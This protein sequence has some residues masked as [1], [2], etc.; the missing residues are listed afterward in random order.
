MKKLLIFIFA[1]ML[2]ASIA[3]VSAAETTETPISLKTN[4]GPDCAMTVVGAAGI[5]MAAISQVMQAA[6][7]ILAPQAAATGFLVNAVTS[8]IPGLSDVLKG[9]ECVDNPSA[10]ATDQL[11]NVATNLI[12]SPAGPLIK[13]GLQSCT[14]AK[15]TLKSIGANKTVDIKVDIQNES[16]KSEYVGNAKVNDLSELVGQ[17]PGSGYLVVPNGTEVNITNDNGK[18]SLK[19]KGSVE[20]VKIGDK[21][22]GNLKNAEFRLDKENQIEFAEF[23]TT[24]VSNYNFSY[25]GTDYKII[26]D[27]GGHVLFDP[28]N[29][30]IEGKNNVYLEFSE[31]NYANG[32]FSVDLNSDGSINKVTLL[33]KNSFYKIGDYDIFAS[34]DASVGIYFNKDDVIKETNSVLFLKDDITLNGN[35]GVREWLDEKIKYNVVGSDRTTAE[36]TRKKDKDNLNMDLINVKAGSLYVTSQIVPGLPD[37][38]LLVFGEGN[39]ASLKDNGYLEWKSGEVV[40][41]SDKLKELIGRFPEMPAL[42][43]EAVTQIITMDDV[44]K[45]LKDKN[46][47]ALE[48]D[49]KN[50]KGTL[51][52]D[53]IK[54]LQYQ[55]NVLKADK[56]FE[57]GDYEKA[58]ADYRKLGM[59]EKAIDSKRKVYEATKEKWQKVKTA[60]LQLTDKINKEATDAV[61][62]MG[63]EFQQE[64]YNQKVT[65]LKTK[66]GFDRILKATANVADKLKAETDKYTSFVKS[67]T[68]TYS[69]S[70]PVQLIDTATLPP[71]QQK[72][73]TEEYDITVSLIDKLNANEYDTTFIGRDDKTKDL[74]KL[75]ETL[76]R[77]QNPETVKTI[78]EYLSI[79]A[80][81]A[82]GQALTDLRFLKEKTVNLPEESELKQAVSS[83]EKDDNYKNWVI[84][85]ELSNIKNSGVSTGTYLS[86]NKYLSDDEKNQIRKTAAVQGI[87]SAE[88]EL[89]IQM[90]NNIDFIKQNND[91]YAGTINVLSSDAPWWNKV[92]E[93][94]LSAAGDIGGIAIDAFNIARLAKT[95]DQTIKEESDKIIK[96][97]NAQ[98]NSINKLNNL[99]PNDKRLVL[100]E[101]AKHSKDPNYIMAFKTFKV[102]KD[103]NKELTPDDIKNI[104]AAEKK[105]DFSLTRSSIAETAKNENEVKA[106]DIKYRLANQIDTMKKNNLDMNFQNA[107]LGYDDTNFGTGVLSFA[108]IAVFSPVSL[109]KNVITNAPADYAKAED[110]NA[111]VLD[112]NQK[113]TDIIAE[114][115]SQ[116]K[117]ISDISANIGNLNLDAN[118]LANVKFALKNDADIMRIHA[119]EMEANGDVS[120]A[121]KLRANAEIKNSELNRQIGDL[122][123]A[124]ANLETASA[125]DPSKD[126]SKDI[127]SI[128]RQ[129]TTQHIIKTVVSMGDFAG[130]CYTLGVI[131]KGVMA[132]ATKFKVAAKVESVLGKI[133]FGKFVESGKMASALKTANTAMK[134]ISR[135]ETTSKF[136]GK[137]VSEDIILKA[138]ALNKELTL[139]T[140]SATATAKAEQIA[141][142][143]NKAKLETSIISPQNTAL[144]KLKEAVKEVITPV[145]GLYDPRGFFK[146]FRGLTE[147]SALGQVG[148]APAEGG[149]GGE[150]IS[151]ADLKVVS[152][153]AVSAVTHKMP[154]G[155]DTK[156]KEKFKEFVNKN[157][158][159]ISGSKAVYKGNR[160]ETVVRGNTDVVLRSG[161]KEIK[162]DNL[163]DVRF[164][165]SEGKVS[166]LN[167]RISETA[168]NTKYESLAKELEDNA[169]AAATDVDKKNIKNE[170][171]LLAPVKE[172]DAAKENTRLAEEKI[173]EAES[174]GEDTSQLKADY[175]NA[176]KEQNQKE[177]NYH[178]AK[179]EQLQKDILDLNSQISEKQ[180]QLEKETNAKKKESVSNDIQKLNFQLKDTETKTAQYKLLEKEALFKSAK[181]ELDINPDAK[182]KFDSASK[183]YLDSQDNLLAKTIDK[184]NLMKDILKN[185][186]AKGVNIFDKSVQLR[187]IKNQIEFSESLISD[188]ESQRSQLSN[189]RSIASLK[190]ELNSKESLSA[191]EAAV[192]KKIESLD[193]LNKKVAESYDKQTKLIDQILNADTADVEKVDALKTEILNEITS[194]KGIEDQ[195]AATYNE[196]LSA[197]KPLIETAKPSAEAVQPTAEIIQLA[198]EKAISGALPVEKQPVAVKITAESVPPEEIIKPEHLAMLKAAGHAS[199][200]ELSIISDVIDSTIDKYQDTVIEFLSKQSPEYAKLY[201]GALI[202]NLH[203]T[204]A[205]SDIRIDSLQGEI[206]RQIT[207]MR[208]DEINFKL[209]IKFPVT[210][211]TY[212][213]YVKIG[214]EKYGM[215]LAADSERG[216]MD[217][218]TGRRFLVI[219]APDFARL[220]GAEK[221]RAYKQTISHESA[222]VLTL[223]LGDLIIEKFNKRNDWQQIKQMFYDSYPE[224][225]DYKSDSEVINEILSFRAENKYLTDKEKQNYP[226]RQQFLDFIEKNV[227]DK[228]IKDT[229]NK[230]ITSTSIAT[231]RI[232]ETS[233][234]SNMMLEFAAEKPAAFKDPEIESAAKQRIEGVLPKLKQLMSIEFS[235]NGKE[236]LLEKTYKMY[237]SK[238]AGTIK[239]KNRDEEGEYLFDNVINPVSTA[240]KLVK[241]TGIEFSAEIEKDMISKVSD[242]IV[243]SGVTEAD[244]L[245]ALS[246]VNAVMRDAAKKQ[247]DEIAKDAIISRLNPKIIEKFKEY[248]E[249]N[250][251]DRIDNKIS[252]DE[253]KTKIESE[254]DIFSKMNDLNNHLSGLNSFVSDSI[255]KYPETSDLIKSVHDR[256][257]NGEKITDMINDVGRSSNNIYLS[258]LSAAQRSAI[259]IEQTLGPQFLKEKAPGE[260]PAEL[261]KPVTKEEID[262]YI[263]ILPNSLGDVPNKKA[264]ED[265]LSENTKSL[266]PSDG[267][268]YLAKVSSILDLANKDSYPVMH[269]IL[270]NL[271][272]ADAENFYEKAKELYTVK[273]NHPL[274][275]YEMERLLHLFNGGK[276]E[277]IKDIKITEE[278]NDVPP[279]YTVS[280]KSKDGA[281]IAD[282]NLE[283]YR[284]DKENIIQISSLKI[285]PSVYIGD[286]EIDMTMGVKYDKTS[287][288]GSDQLN[289]L[290]GIYKGV[291]RTA[292]KEGLE[293][294]TFDI[295][296]KNPEL[297]RLALSIKDY[298]VELQDFSGLK[299][300]KLKKS[301]EEQ[302]IPKSTIKKIIKDATDKNGNID[303]EKVIA[304]FDKLGV[305]DDRL[306]IDDVEIKNMIEGGKDINGN[307][308]Y[309]KIGAGFDKIGISSK[310][311]ENIFAK[312]RTIEDDMSI[313]R[314]E[315]RSIIQIKTDLIKE[316][317]LREEQARKIAEDEIKREEAKRLQEEADKQA[318]IISSEEMSKAQ[319]EA[320]K[321]EQPKI[322]S[323]KDILVDY[324]D[325]AID[326]LHARD[327]LKQ[328]KLAEN[329][330]DN[331]MVKVEEKKAEKR[332]GIIK[333][334]KGEVIIE[335]EKLAE[336]ESISKDYYQII[337]TRVHDNIVDA[338][339][340]FNAKLIDGSFTNTIKENIEAAQDGDL[341][342]IIYFKVNIEG[343]KKWGNENG[344]TTVTYDTN[345]K[346]ILLGPFPNKFLERISEQSVEA[347]LK[348]PEE[349]KTEEL[350]GP[351]IATTDKMYDAKEWN[352]NY[353]YKP[354]LDEYKRPLKD[355]KTG[356]IK[357]PYE[358]RRYED[359]GKYF[360]DE[361][362]YSQKNGRYSEALRQFEIAKTVS[363]S[364]SDIYKKA[365]EMIDNLRNQKAE[366]QLAAAVPQFLAEKA[367]VPEASAADVTKQIE[368]LKLKLKDP[369]V[370]VRMQAVTELGKIG[371]PAIPAVIELLKDPDVRDMATEILGNMREPAV[372]PLIEALKSPDANV[373]WKATIA[374]GNIFDRR[375]IEPLARLIK[376][377]D[378][379]VKQQAILVVGRFIHIGEIPAVIE[380]VPALIEEFKSSSNTV[381]THYAY[382]M[383]MEIGKPAVP[384]LIEALKDPNLYMSGR[385]ARALGGIR[386]ERAIQPLIELMKTNSMI[387]QTTSAALAEIGEPAVPALIELLKDHEK[388][389]MASHTLRRIGEPAVPALIELLKDPDAIVRLRA[390]VVLGDVEDSRAINPLIEL[391]KDPDG[392]VRLSAVNSLGEIKDVKAIPALISIAMQDLLLKGAAFDSLNIINPALREINYDETNLKI[393]NEYFTKEKEVI[394]PTRV[395]NY[396]E[397]LAENAKKLDSISDDG[398][399]WQAIKKITADVDVKYKKFTDAAFRNEKVDDYS[400]YV[401]TLGR[402]DEELKD[403]LDN[404]A[405]EMKISTEG[406]TIADLM[407]EIDS[408]LKTVDIKQQ[409]VVSFDFKKRNVELKLPADYETALKDNIKAAL[410]VR[411]LGDEQ[412]QSI[413][414]K[415]TEI[416]SKVDN[417]DTEYLAKNNVNPKLIE[418]AKTDP[419]RKENIKAQLYKHF[420]LSQDE[421]N[422]ILLK[423]FERSDINLI[424]KYSGE[425]LT[426]EEKNLFIQKFSE[427]EISLNDELETLGLGQINDNI[428]SSDQWSVIKDLKKNMLTISEKEIKSTSKIEIVF[429]KK[430]VIDLGY[431]GFSGTCFEPVDVLGEKVMVT[432]I[433]ENGELAGSVLFAIQKDKL[434]MLGFD[435][436]ESLVA[437]LDPAKKNEFIDNVMDRIYNFADKNNFKLMI[438]TQAGGLSNRGFQDY[439][440]KKY[441]TSNKINVD[442]MTYQPDYK[443]KVTY[444]FEA[445][446]KPAAVNEKLYVPSTDVI[447]KSLI[448]KELVKQ[449]KNTIAE[450]IQYIIENPSDEILDVLHLRAFRQIS[451]DIANIDVANLLKNQGLTAEDAAAK[452]NLVVGRVD[453]ISDE[454]VLTALKNMP[455]G[456][457]LFKHMEKMQL[458]TD[459][460]EPD[461]ENYLP[462]IITLRGAILVHD[463]GKLGPVDADKDTKKVIFDLFEVPALDPELKIKEAITQIK[464]DERYGYKFPESDNYYLDILNKVG[465]KS[466]DSISKLWNKHYEWGEDWMNTHL[467]EDSATY[468]IAKW[469]GKLAENDPVISIIDT[470]DALVSRP[471]YDPEKKR[472][473]PPKTHDE[474]IESIKSDLM[475]KGMKRSATFKGKSN[476]ELKQTPEYANYLK[477]LDLINQKKDEILNPPKRY[478]I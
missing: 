28:S 311:K 411:G 100:E 167:N 231:N 162:I 11:F 80:D 163:Q 14:N 312:L 379:Q 352:P 207:S 309:E 190:V 105:T 197:A 103:S 454:R 169:K 259:K 422:S 34:S 212:S 301:Y 47:D 147:F 146:G 446:E 68:T 193:K 176:L 132:G 451:S 318:K 119:D 124:K 385:A 305:R 447:D 251:N 381:V 148:G 110:Y 325:G 420:E 241:K 472:E 439:I 434:I 295:Y 30:K 252:A 427:M 77:T 344:I 416:S 275:T 210:P 195:L 235:E 90:K 46:I 87:G 109:I 185:E 151:L 337:A 349:F 145:T 341:G 44:N 4:L 236:V 117:S 114:L 150:K 91:Y 292:K 370:N 357:Y 128:G 36:I 22:F 95:K 280:V 283:I 350:K 303:N 83:I 369:D 155:Y 445:K 374:L 401:G 61:S 40:I 358:A 299:S 180:S 407:K 254:K 159:E 206:I 53:E 255:Y 220:K 175:S 367:A 267:L 477:I 173:K 158:G 216:L 93:V 410:D 156:L 338:K 276:T 183:E 39:T 443:Y 245:L 170:Q 168:I 368:D 433:L 202:L 214:G 332:S 403:N 6:N 448:T 388:G 78:T 278:K 134:E 111:N 102:F 315:E 56:E 15:E 395:Y 172:I 33:K 85:S 66:Y 179:T 200:E 120:S 387:W 65:E 192:S 293:K 465:L 307:F 290:E 355:F 62:G 222:H 126:L 256:I 230:I 271:D 432:K 417:F 453:Q 217:E 58:S 101:I 107:N 266:T 287:E 82:D 408:K 73:L 298:Y 306:E 440:M 108:K 270:K 153:I 123:A 354:P 139:A 308:D 20:A 333:Q 263:K 232:I 19:F 474:A 375:S 300:E 342:K 178:A 86:K 460:L 41:T 166:E 286:R 18:I 320:V 430:S 297:E 402:F 264:F 96:E 261:T 399:R 265:L 441:A 181:S 21:V 316:K 386:D 45:H 238:E 464:K 476:E 116:G 63:M 431:G 346:P 340:Y 75:R 406:K 182:S 253:L 187:E 221:I 455:Q 122:A 302:D 242:K 218:T 23:D 149:E 138:Q 205:K 240:E 404:V 12:P 130:A 335:L 99:E 429:K 467:P 239:F 246:D 393:I 250:I 142:L 194:R 269:E 435:P 98:L 35:A 5:N 258:H 466:G 154:K 76:Q 94:P 428:K 384:A 272:T 135:L 227:V 277:T 296:S 364:K 74:I 152:D 31:K 38:K 104:E 478:I 372:L 437:S 191:D 423:T 59:D 57:S 71:K 257:A 186:K 282:A 461:I 459:I 394:S 353:I 137:E 347:M 42:T 345:G 361:A 121:N 285:D 475:F 189:Q 70:P 321:N 211:I 1:M 106:A 327:K 49:L 237:E 24:A 67:Y 328:N 424:K 203:H 3:A 390:V 13:A 26:A 115:V 229:Y 470:Y 291:L 262:Y 456:T 288:M 436:S 336:K 25:G 438:T 392:D 383:I 17:K 208:P 118:S 376:D 125:L 363:S 442:P 356:K 84:Q 157:S 92:W 226:G 273:E 247:A 289:L 88:N 415:I 97:T 414:N 418:L 329:A 457:I 248:G 249:K 294:F 284:S 330:I 204:T 243:T 405:E 10:C 260:L 188:A 60:E 215:A 317:A 373:R 7:I 449:S 304:G 69:Y 323:V 397:Q 50:A 209:N 143:A 196:V 313:S 171:E 234:K 131:G 324:F 391:F 140:D 343:L 8:V 326:T 165:T 463:L 310:D 144:F 469:H 161:T 331:I 32:D 113:A 224:Y 43:S 458:L 133:G 471:S 177:A 322:A 27:K 314:I 136:L 184:E 48:N 29:K 89:N 450:N 473:V 400:F 281:K 174:N 64:M 389:S 160:Y 223:Q 81:K 79:T 319:Q 398:K 2:L 378:I 419:A 16:I 198:A 380:A 129:I 213:D 365:S 360:F 412:I 199:K 228:E 421:I 274:S 426:K 279:F 72:Q 244:R 366:Q 409:Y 225:K 127:S 468:Q 362:V 334:S 201:E 268:G 371:E 348:T 396:I 351:I 425:I 141:S 112:V 413:K 55:I 359:E 51:Q 462:D 377:P 452:A 9:K 54:Y 233:G 219:N 444:A 164:L 339:E 382:I 52:D 37:N